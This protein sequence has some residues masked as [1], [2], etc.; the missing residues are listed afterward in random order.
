[1]TEFMQR[2]DLCIDATIFALD[3]RLDQQAADFLSRTTKCLLGYGW[4]K[5]S[6]GQSCRA[7]LHLR[8]AHSVQRRFSAISNRRAADRGSRCRRILGPSY[9]RRKRVVIR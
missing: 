5:D 9:R 1:V 2:A 6:A 8:H 4:R 7:G 3:H